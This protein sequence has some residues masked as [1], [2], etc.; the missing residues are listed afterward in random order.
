MRSGS[1]CGARDRVQRLRHGHALAGEGRLVDLQ[2]AHG[3]EPSVRSDDLPGRENQEIATAHVVGP[4][5]AFEPAPEHSRGRRR[6]RAQGLERPLGPPVGGESECDRKGDRRH[7]RQGVAGVSEEK[8]GDAGDEQDQ[9]HPAF[10]LRPEDPPDLSGGRGPR[11]GRSGSGGEVLDR[12][13]RLRV[14]SQLPGH[15]LEGAGV[16]VRRGIA[17]AVHSPGHRFRT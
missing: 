7:D 4:D 10:E 17:C 13:A 3:R 6:K 15:V 8:G 16:P 1:G 5:L 11:N 9:D 14:R 12:Q 2:I